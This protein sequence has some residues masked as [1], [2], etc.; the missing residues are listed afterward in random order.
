VI[1]LKLIRRKALG[2]L[3]AGVAFSLATNAFPQIH[4]GPLNTADQPV[5]LL[6][7]YHNPG[8]KGAVG[9]AKATTH[10]TGQPANSQVVERS[11]GT[12]A[13]DG[14]FT[15][16][17][18]FIREPAGLEVPLGGRAFQFEVDMDAAPGP[19]PVLMTPTARFAAGA[20]W[21]VGTTGGGTL[22]QVEITRVLGGYQFWWRNTAGTTMIGGVNHASR[23]QF[24]VRVV[25]DAPGTSA[26]VIITPLDGTVGNADMVFA[27]ALV[28]GPIGTAGFAAGMY[29]ADP[30]TGAP[31]IGAGPIINGSAT[32]DARGHV[33]MG[34]FIT[35][36]GDSALYLDALTPW[37][38]NNAASG[39]GNLPGIAGMPAYYMW[40]L[41]TPAVRTFA[42]QA[43]VELLEGAS[44]TDLDGAPGVEPSVPAGYST[45]PYTGPVDADFSVGQ[46][47]FDVT[48]PAPFNG[49]LRTDDDA[50]AT[51]GNLNTQEVSAGAWS[52]AVVSPGTDDS[53]SLVRTTH[54]LTG[55]GSSTTLVTGA[56]R[57]SYRP[58][59]FFAPNQATTIQNQTGNPIATIRREGETTNLDNTVPVI[60]GVTLNGSAIT[61]LTV[62]QQGDLTL[63]F[64]AH[65]NGV[66]PSPI[67]STTG[68]GLSRYP[69]VVLR[70]LS[71]PGNLGSAK[72]Y[73]PG[74]LPLTDRV[75]PADDQAFEVNGT[76]GTPG[77][78]NVTCGTQYRFVI[79]VEDRVGLV[80]THA[81]A[82][83]E[84][85]LL[86]NIYVSLRIAG[87]AGSNPDAIHAAGA[88][89]PGGPNSQ[90][91]FQRWITFWVGGT[92]DGLPDG[93]GPHIGPFR[94]D[95]LVLFTAGGV[96]DNDPSTLA[97]EPIELDPTVAQPGQNVA[98]PCPGPQLWVTV[99]DRQHTLAET[100]M[101]VA[102]GGGSSNY[103]VSFTGAPGPNGAVGD[104]ALKLGDLNDDDIVGIADFGLFLSKYGFIYTQNDITVIGA[105]RPA[106]VT[107]HADL[108]GDRLV[109]AADYL[110]IFFRNN[111]FSDPYVTSYTSLR[112]GDQ[113]RIRVSEL[114][115]MGIKEATR[116]D[117]NHDGWVTWKEME[118]VLAMKMAGRWK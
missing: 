54:D 115:R 35:N 113:T 45:L 66:G 20:G 117:F 19:F 97:I 109:N 58:L 42:W 87:F 100:N 34:Q 69:E 1:D 15:P 21:E 32:P 82:I 94:Y 9:N 16:F 48:M 25:F 101:A 50:P 8:N 110:Q 6:G 93:G 51:G 52:I 4:G 103:A 104:H 79:W 67:A 108:N 90:N 27:V 59:D 49:S 116:W 57:P 38:T 78:I 28:G 74:D 10:E 63:R 36:G 96:A 73:G 53:H 14:T 30:V 23:T 68:T 102:A 44:L 26:T 71:V 65:D 118:Q 85:R 99:K 24:R 56:M 55:K 106:P 77:S 43:F 105:P 37:R 33:W 60:E 81:S 40:G 22:A 31:V 5:D 29:T 18:D 72:G 89:G 64:R 62:I 47:V 12:L 92:P 39:G 107:L 61:V 2:L 11:G 91:Y 80:T 7:N 84:I 13:E 41:S 75:Y 46:F 86:N 88:P 70:N 76:I 3:A 111:N 95:R 83:F 17:D 98:R 112:P 114:L